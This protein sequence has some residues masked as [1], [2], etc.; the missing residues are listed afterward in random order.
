MNAAAD[1]SQLHQKTCFNGSHA[2]VSMQLAKISQRND[3][4]VEEN[5]RLFGRPSDILKFI[6]FPK[7]NRTFCILN[8]ESTKFKLRS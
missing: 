6:L 3:L 7:I 4:L 1:H 2:R 5:R 8:I